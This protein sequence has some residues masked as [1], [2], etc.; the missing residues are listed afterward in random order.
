MR[1]GGRGRGYLEK[2]P[3]S[4]GKFYSSSFLVPGSQI[5]NLA[6]Q[7]IN[8]WPREK[9]VVVVFYT[10]IFP[11]VLKKIFLKQNPTHREHKEDLILK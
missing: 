10:V 11:T 3:L 6:S 9:H 2:Q 1:G 7:P 4:K 5:K 8:T